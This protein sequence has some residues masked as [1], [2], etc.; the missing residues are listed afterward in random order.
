MPL[1]P[2]TCVRVCVRYSQNLRLYEDH[3]ASTSSAL[4]CSV[5]V[6]QSS[7]RQEAAVTRLRALLTLAFPTRVKHAAP[8]TGGAG[9]GVWWMRDT[10]QMWPRP[11]ERH[12]EE[13][14]GRRS[15]ETANM[16][17]HFSLS[18]HFPLS[19]VCFFVSALSFSVCVCVCM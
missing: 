1:T 10:R 11:G 7:E 3:S 8:C 6:S 14:G 15:A 17:S 12:E 2:L 9:G 18:P 4:F 5:I 16:K 13:E 19:S